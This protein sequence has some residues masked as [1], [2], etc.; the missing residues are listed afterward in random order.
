MQHRCGFK[1]LALNR[2][3]AGIVGSGRPSA[4]IVNPQSPE[5]RLYSSVTKGATVSKL[6][7]ST[8]RTGTASGLTVILPTW[9]GPRQPSR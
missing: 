9:F 5:N 6:A 4:E 1:L 3:L 8:D 2:D 7:S